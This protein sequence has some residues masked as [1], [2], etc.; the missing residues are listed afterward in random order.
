MV[1]GIVKRGLSRAT[2]NPAFTP[3]LSL[4]EQFC[5]HRTNLLRTLTY[6]R[7]A[8]PGSSGKL[9]PTILS[10]TPDVFQKQMEFLSR[11]YNVLSLTELH[12]SI[13]N[14][15]PLPPKSVLITFDDAYRD[16]A[17]IAW[18][19]LKQLGIPATLFVPT[20]YPDEPERSFWWD[21]LFQNLYAADETFELKTDHESFLL[22]SLPQ[23]MDVF[24]KLT[25]VVKSLPNADALAFVDSICEQ[26]GNLPVENHV[27]GWN[28]LSALATDGVTLGAH[29]RT[30]PLMNRLTLD[31]ARQEAVESQRDLERH[32]GPLLPVF[33]YP[34]GGVSDDVS[35]ILKEEGFQLAFTTSRGIN[36]LNSADLL[37]LKRIN[38]GR[39]TSQSLLRAQLLPWMRYW[40]R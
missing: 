18:P 20:A 10:A 12:E 36:D 31:E 21:R 7:V 30:H 37:Q 24:R 6:H 25:E 2:K 35:A 13:S 9:D 33:A 4:F 39:R 29:T 34:A 40:N 15:E 38:I 8:E 26:L 11:R 27:L 16:F 3:F 28:E 32:I 22:D 23:K 5:D 1:A 17:E 19:I 14:G